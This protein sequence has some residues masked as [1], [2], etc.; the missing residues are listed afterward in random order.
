MAEN[1]VINVVSYTEWISITNYG[2]SKL[3]TD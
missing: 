2:I 3:I 1:Q